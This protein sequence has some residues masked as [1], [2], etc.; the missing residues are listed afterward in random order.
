MATKN[1]ENV[2]LMEL[3]VG[4]SCAEGYVPEMVTT[5]LSRGQGRALKHLVAALDESHARLSNGRP[6]FDGASA[7]RYVLEQYGVTQPGSTV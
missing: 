6:V 7:V 5:R 1:K 2:V 4:D 3:P